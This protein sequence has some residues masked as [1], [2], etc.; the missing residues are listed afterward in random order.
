MVGLRVREKAYV[1]MSVR[2]C[3]YM[4]ACVC[5]RASNKS[6]KLTVAGRCDSRDRHGNSTPYTL[7]CLICTISSEFNYFLIFTIWGEPG[8]MSAGLQWTNSTPAE[9]QEAFRAATCALKPSKGIFQIG[10]V[11]MRCSRPH[12]IPNSTRKHGLT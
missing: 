8:L 3:G 1:R 12:S 5:V 6:S 2:M 10:E 9:F 11:I 7:F 4:C